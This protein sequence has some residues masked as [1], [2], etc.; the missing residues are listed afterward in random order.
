MRKENLSP[1]AGKP[2]SRPLLA[3]FALALALASCDLVFRL[4]HSSLGVSERAIAHAQAWMLHKR[5]PYFQAH[6][7]V[8]FRLRPER[9][10]SNERGLAG[11]LPPLERTPGVPRVVLLGGSARRAGV[12]AGP[13]QRLGPALQSALSERTGTPIELIDACLPAWS[14]AEAL[15]WWSLE[16]Q[17]LQPDLVIAHPAYADALAAEPGA[18][19]DYRGWRRAWP[20]DALSW[21]VGE[22]VLRSPL[23]AWLRAR[24]LERSVFARLRGTPLS[25]A[26]LAPERGLE[27]PLPLRNWRSLDDLVRLSGARVVQL[28]LPLTEVRESAGP[29]AELARSLV[30]RLRAQN[31]ALRDWAR[32]AGVALVDLEELFAA[33]EP[34]TDCELGL[35]RT[36]SGQERMA[37]ALASAL[38]SQGLLP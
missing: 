11:P 5:S 19:R 22:L 15:I 16:G 2:R 13:K 14:S 7:Y 12:D 21:P 38:E 25:E 28:T 4:A 8:N 29:D 17:D 18:G 26:E 36:A 20:E 23:C 10:F 3:L 34:L 6:A 9:A 27:E 33:D 35:L 1:P 30:R 24:L 37:Q 32:E 31:A